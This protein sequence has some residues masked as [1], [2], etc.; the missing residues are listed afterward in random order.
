MTGLGKL[1]SAWFHQPGINDVTFNRKQYLSF[2][3]FALLI[4]VFT[5]PFFSPEIHFGMDGSEFF[6]FNYLFYHHIQFGTSVVFT[7]GPLGF[8]CGPEYLG[9]NLIIAIVLINAIR[10][11]FIYGFLMFGFLVNKSHRVFHILLAIG[12]CNLA[13]ID[14]IFVGSAIVTMLLFH[15]RKKIIWLAL[16]CLLGSVALLVKSSYGV[17]S[18]AILFSYALYTIIWH[19]RV[20]VFLNTCIFIFCSLFVIWFTLYHSFSGI[21]TYFQAMY[22]F[23]KD[24]SSAYQINV[25]N[26][27]GILGLALVFFFLPLLFNKSELTKLLY[28]ISVAGLYAAFKYSFAREENWHLRFLFDFCITFFALFI[29]LNTSSKP[30]IIMLPLAAIT[31]LYCNICMTNAYAI[32][33]SVSIISVDNFMKFVIHYDDAIR[34]AKKSS[35]VKLLDEEQRSIIGNSTVDCYPLE[36][37]YVIADTLNWEPRPTLQIL[38]YTPWLDSHNASF[39]SSGN[40]P[41]FYVWQLSPPPI[42]LYSVDD[43]YLLNEEPISI[44]EFFKHYQLINANSKVAL[45]RHTDA[46]LLGDEHMTGSSEGN[47]NKWINIPSTDS[48]TVLR[49]KIHFHNTYKGVLR[50]TFYKDQIYFIDYMLANGII[51]SHRL[52]PGNAVSGVWINPLVSDITKGPGSGEKVKAIRIRVTGSGYIKDNFSIDWKTFRIL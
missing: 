46:K 40:A 17:I 6:A 11:V 12:I 8:L 3:G 49:A 26:H 21:F 31:L 9:N 39:L 2:A 38:S 14:M 36:L 15:L 29:L 43:H 32:G 42:S 34:E 52:V 5:F 47:I 10:F 20:D 44:Y 51:E 37:T 41:R 18:M 4:L 33:N 35:E 28:F 27:W 48:L 25:V 1:F 16:G 50:K 7:Y 22:Q 45:F 13:Y 23:S 19:K 30:F 24:N